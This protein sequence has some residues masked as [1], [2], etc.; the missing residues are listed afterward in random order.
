MSLDNIATPD[1]GDSGPEP[2]PPAAV[3]NHPRPRLQWLLLGLAAIVGV[4]AGT[5]LGLS[6]G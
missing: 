6:M 2:D 5:G 4:A 3:V 1:S